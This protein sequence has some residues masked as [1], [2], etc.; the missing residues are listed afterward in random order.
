MPQL[1]RM[2]ILTW[3]GG[4]RKSHIVHITVKYTSPGMKSPSPGM[5]SPSPSM[6]SPSLLV[7]NH[8]LSFPL[9]L[10]HIMLNEINL[11]ENIGTQY[12]SLSLWLL[13]MVLCRSRAGAWLQTWTLQIGASAPVDYLRR[14]MDCGIC[15]TR[16]KLSLQFWLLWHYLRARSWLHAG[17]LLE[18]SRRLEPCQWNKCNTDLVKFVLILFTD[19]CF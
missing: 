7:W 15:M 17:R 9:S 10:I 11:H 3:H 8:R 5:K 6:K 2:W 12:L 18:L 19:G 4:L 13:F 1:H 16:H 14:I